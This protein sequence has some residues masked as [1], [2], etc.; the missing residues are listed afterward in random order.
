ME[1]EN[2]SQP[3]KKTKM[4]AYVLVAAAIA[5][6]GGILFGFDTGVISGAILFIVKQWNLTHKQAELATSSVLI[7]AVLGALAGGLLGDRLGRRLS[8]IYATVLF[9][10]GTLIVSIADGMT[11]FLIGRVLIGAAIGV[12]SFMVPLYISELAP[13]HIRGS[14]VSLNQFAVTVGILVS[15]G[16]NY[17]YASTQN[18][19]AMFAVGA[20]P[21]LILLFGM[22]AL[23]DSPRWLFSVGLREAAEKVLRKIR[24]TPEVTEELAEID[25]AIRSESG[26]KVSDLLAPP[27]RLALIIGV[28]LAILQ[29]V[30]GV[31][32]VIY[33][34]PAI[35]KGAGLQSDTAAIA[36]TSGIGVVNVLF[37]GVSLWLIDRVGRR[38]LLLWSVAGMT[39]ALM[40]LGLGFAL[41]GD[42]AEAGG[43]GLGLITAVTL[44]VYIAF[45]AIGLGPIFWLLI[46][47]IYPLKLRAPGMSV[48]TVANWGANFVVAYTF[49]TLASLLGKAGIFW[50]YGLMGVITWL[51]VDRLVPET[52]G[53]TL[54]EIEEYFITR[55]GPSRKG[56]EQ[57]GLRRA[58]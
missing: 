39:V 27:V 13:A 29:Q 58:S 2:V 11:S 40:V 48:A 36:A 38:P 45:F 17:Y 33:Y 7:G 14:M 52:K 46:A 53:K 34:A 1:K 49:L 37:T 30:T 44:M 12:A 5:A 43:G 10:A 24:G 47:E 54:E 16:V 15:Y 28:G 55:A 25:E 3:G 32:T 6:I 31:N 41:R 9:L 22:Y 8:I 21:G 18:W 51:F 26:G 23:P 42:E 19:R 57:S 35:F 20:V 56:R 4:T 50:F